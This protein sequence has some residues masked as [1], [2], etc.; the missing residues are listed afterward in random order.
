MVAP[1]TMSALAEGRYDVFMS[2]SHVDA[3]WVEAL[4]RRLDDEHRVRPW[5][6]RWVLIPGKPWQQEMARG[7]EE[8]SSCAVCLGQKTPRGWFEKEI[9]KALNRQ[10]ND[11]E[12][13]VIPVL[14]P[15]A[16][17]ALADSLQGT[18]LDLNTWVDFRERADQERSLHLLVCGVKGIAPG[19]WTP[20]SA[21]SQASKDVVDRLAQLRQLRQERLVD[22]EVALDIQRKILEALLRDI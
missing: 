18:F 2:H 17:E 12:F 21:G 3:D 22:D 10:A 8:A 5:L 13:R 7:L 19:R 15:G 9:Q 14:L 6:D 20:P 16:D 11:G 1:G 4:A